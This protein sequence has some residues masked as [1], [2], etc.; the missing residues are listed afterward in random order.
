M[1]LGFGVAILV[2]SGGRWLGLSGLQAMA[3]FYGLAFAF[4]IFMGF[5]K[6]KMQHTQ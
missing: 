5:F 6:N 1:L 3:G 2:F 4:T